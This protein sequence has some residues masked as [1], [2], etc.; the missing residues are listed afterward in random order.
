MSQKD[1]PPRVNPVVDPRYSRS[2]EY[3]AAIL[4]CFSAEC[5]V[6]R[7]SEMADMIGVSRSTTHRYS[8]TLVRLGYLEQDEKRRYRLAHGAARPGIAAIGVL[9]GELHAETILEELRERTRATVSLGVLEG[10]RVVYVHRFFAHKAG[11]YEADL[12]LGVGAYVPVH[13]TAIGKALLASLGESEQAAILA[14]LTLA[15]HGPKTI[16]SKRKLADELARFRLEGIAVCDEEQAAGVRSIAKAVVCPGAPRLMAISVTAPAR[17]YTVSR[18]R[19]D[20]GAHLER[21][22]TRVRMAYGRAVAR[23]ERPTGGERRRGG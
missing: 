12:G 14:N 9:C 18:L 22:A 6:L 7:I 5:P 8:M 13:C 23:D 11:Q 4:E 17:G 1:R 16:A 10:S 21:A 15:R 20:F 3:G 19:D 2:L